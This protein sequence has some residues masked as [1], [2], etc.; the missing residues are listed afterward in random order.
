MFNDMCNF[1]PFLHR[2]QFFSSFV[3][4]VLFFPW[5][6]IAIS[7]PRSFYKFNVNYNNKLLFV[8]TDKRNQFIDKNIKRH[9]ST[10]G[11]LKNRKVF[12]DWIVLNLINQR[13][14]NVFPNI[15]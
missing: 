15:L 6:N 12:Q 8:K 9:K 13:I 7:K 3:L 10:G 14:K 4:F 5:L 11:I 2:A 1:P